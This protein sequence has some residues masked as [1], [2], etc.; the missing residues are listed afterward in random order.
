MLPVAPSA[1][2]LSWPRLAEHWTRQPR[3]QLLYF[4]SIPYNIIIT[5]LARIIFQ[6]Y[7][8]SSPIESWAEIW[9]PSPLLFPKTERWSLKREC[10]LALRLVLGGEG[11][12]GKKPSAKSG[13]HLSCF[14]LPD[15]FWIPLLC[16]GIFLLL[17]S[18]FSKVLVR[19]LFSQ[20]PLKLGYSMWP[21]LHHHLH[22]HRALIYTRVMGRSSNH[23]ESP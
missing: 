9:P 11:W 12:G 6:N 17:E 4:I 13:V 14:R 19:N 2:G 16:L 3:G 15:S 18:C 21:G 7:S 1:L 20:H 10:A 22:W 8:R 23:V 5:R